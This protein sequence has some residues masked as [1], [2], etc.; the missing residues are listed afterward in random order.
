MRARRLYRPAEQ[1]CKATDTEMKTLKIV[2]DAA[3]RCDDGTL[4][5]SWF[6]KETEKQKQT[7]ILFK[8]IERER[9]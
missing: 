3:K 6:S 2:C 5:V 4:G 7:E 8:I 1:V 9:E